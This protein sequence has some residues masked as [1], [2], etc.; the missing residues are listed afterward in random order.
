MNEHILFVI[1]HLANT[2][3]YTKEELEAN[4]DA[5]YW[6]VY[7]SRVS[8]AS[9]AA[10]LE[11]AARAAASHAAAASYWVDEYFK[12]SDEDKQIYIDALGE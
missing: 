6:A 9:R 12:R 10:T 7:V 3:K 1:D 4:Y 2:G 5:A 8:R 11:A